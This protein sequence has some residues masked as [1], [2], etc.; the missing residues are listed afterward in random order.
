MHNGKYVLWITTYKLKIKT[1]SL[2]I[3][4]DQD[5][6]KVGQYCIKTFMRSNN[7]QV[8]VKFISILT[9]NRLIRKF[10]M[11]GKEKRK[12]NFVQFSLKI[13]RKRKEIWTKGYIYSRI[14]R[15]QKMDQMICAWK[16]V[17]QLNQNTV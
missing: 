9:K 7:N 17:E 13:Q 1:I 14:R 6:S 16:D 10:T 8:V 4:I 12:R 15:N 3:I 5:V 2:Q 11:I